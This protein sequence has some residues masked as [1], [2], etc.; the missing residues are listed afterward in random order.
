M[1]RHYVRKTRIDTK[2]SQALR[3]TDKC[4]HFSAAVSFLLLILAGEPTNNPTHKLQLNLHTKLPQWTQTSP[5][6]LHSCSVLSPASV[7]PK[8]SFQQTSPPRSMPFSHSYFLPLLPTFS[9]RL[10]FKYCACA[11]IGY[12]YHT[13][14]SLSCLDLCPSPP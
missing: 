1:F 10:C 7:S 6:V 13:F 9:L 11:A 14:W 3:E 5:M 12:P 8:A 2:V 4:L